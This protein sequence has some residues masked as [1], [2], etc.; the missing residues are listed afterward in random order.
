M[1][2]IHIVGRGAGSFPA[3]RVA[4]SGMAGA[5]LER[6]VVIQKRIL[7]DY[8]G[9]VRQVNIFSTA[10]AGWGDNAATTRIAALQAFPNG[11]Q[12]AGAAT[13]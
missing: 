7:F 4:M 10:S 9:L 13:S 1:G 2:K 5:S 3:A 11:R 8:R 12:P 6:L